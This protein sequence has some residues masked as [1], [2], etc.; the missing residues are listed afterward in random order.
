MKRSYLLLSLFPLLLILLTIFSCP[1]PEI[2][3]DNPL[4]FN[5]SYIVAVWLFDGNGKDSSANG[6]D[7]IP[8]SASVDPIY[9][10][11]QGRSCTTMGTDGFFYINETI[12]DSTEFTVT[13]W[14][15]HM[16]AAAGSLFST[17]D[18]ATIKGFK[19][20]LDAGTKVDVRSDMQIIEDLEDLTLMGKWRHFAVVMNGRN[21]KVYI[22]NVKRLETTLQSSITTKSSF[23]VGKDL[24]NAGHFTETLD[25]MRVFSKALTEEQLTAIYNHEK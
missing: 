14:E 3:Y 23:R 13:F 18:G 11:I 5:N 16:A 17:Y 20:Y 8:A 2:V 15:Y 22:D 25:N 24:N 21:L 12:L 7:L 19:I 10:T 6:R 9:S 4:D 1:F